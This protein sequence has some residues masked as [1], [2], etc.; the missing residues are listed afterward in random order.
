MR[1]GRALSAG[2]LAELATIVLI[3]LVVTLYRV[4]QPARAPGDVEAFGARAGAVLGPLGGA[5]FTFL[6]ALWVARGVRT[7]RIAHGL[8]VA[9]GAIALHLAGALATPDGYRPLYV[10]ADA[11]KLAAGALAGYVAQRRFPA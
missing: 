11:L 3:V 2:I 7:Q 10:M 4:V 1:W 6:F 8:M 9:V 5:V